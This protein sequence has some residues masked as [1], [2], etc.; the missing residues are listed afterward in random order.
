MPKD[1]K[2]PP[3]RLPFDHLRE[4][5]ETDPDGFEALRRLYIDQ[6]INAHGKEAHRLRQLQ[7]RIDGI[8]RR[9]SVNGALLEISGLMWDHFDQMNAFLSE[10]RDPHKKSESLNSA[11]IIPFRR[12]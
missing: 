6:A 10:A 8:R 1:V 5:A 7:F 11:K 3:K 12:L 9:R 2:Q 4:L